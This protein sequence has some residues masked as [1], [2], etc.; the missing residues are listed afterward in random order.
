MG[1]I[2]DLFDADARKRNRIASLTKKAIMLFGQTDDRMG[3]CSGLANINEPDAVRGL[4]RRFTVTVDNKLH[5]QDEKRE[6]SDMLVDLAKDHAKDGS[7]PD[8][9]ALIHEFLAR[10]DEITWAS[11]TLKRVVSE[12][13]WVEALLETLGNHTSED[14]NPEKLGQ[15]LL[16]L[17]DQKDLRVIPAVARCLKDFDDTV[18]FAA[19]E[20]LA[21]I[22]DESARAPLLEALTRPEEDSRRITHRI[23]EVFKEAGWEVKGFRKAVEERLPEGFYLDRSGRIKQLGQGEVKAPET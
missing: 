5:D 19:I 11:R 16:S 13:E 9:V 23:I 18:R 2:A 17:H 21:T 8:V 4:L 12:K 6:V 15:I 10:E 7:A 22:P 20:C 3:A 14:T 1:F